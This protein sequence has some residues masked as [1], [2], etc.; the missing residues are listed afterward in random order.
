VEQSCGL[1]RRHEPAS[2]IGVHRRTPG[3]CICS[4][5]S[6]IRVTIE[7]PMLRSSM[8]RVVQ[9]IEAVGVRQGHT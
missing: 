1:A 2:L 5:L 7:A 6:S 3:W 4:A 9:T 8:N